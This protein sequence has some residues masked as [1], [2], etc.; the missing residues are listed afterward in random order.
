MYVWRMLI[1][2]F[3]CILHIEGNKRHTLHTMAIVDNGL[4]GAGQLWLCYLR[5]VGMLLVACNLNESSG[6]VVSTC[7]T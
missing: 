2:R 3:A 5:E 6:T 7:L 1:E 4:P